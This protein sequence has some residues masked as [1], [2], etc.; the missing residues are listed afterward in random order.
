L[1]GNLWMLIT[2]KTIN[3]I[4]YLDHPAKPVLFSSR[5]QEGNVSSMNHSRCHCWSGIEYRLVNIWDLPVLVLQTFYIPAWPWQ[6]V[7]FKTFMSAWSQYWVQ[8]WFLAGMW[9]I[10]SW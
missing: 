2:N 10:Y 1:L 7:L 9:H 6:W 3:S 4:Q 5:F 8:D